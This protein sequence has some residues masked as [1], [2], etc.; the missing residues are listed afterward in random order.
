[1]NKYTV[2]K[3]TQG[4][5]NYINNI[6]KEERGVVILYDTR[7]M[8]KEFA[9]ATALCLNANG[10]KTYI[11]NNPRPI[12]VLSYAIRVLNTVAGVMITASHNPPEYNG[13]KVM[14]EDGAQIT[15]PID[16]DII[17]RVRK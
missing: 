7:N 10:I 4:L 13:Y 6:G 15:S 12:P 5:A 1:M 9:D 3:A 16:K 14:W 2:T 17:A 11:F 8:S